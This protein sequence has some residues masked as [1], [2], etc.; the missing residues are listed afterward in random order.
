MIHA[1]WTKNRA[2]G[3]SDAVACNL[4]TIAASIRERGAARV[5]A[6]V[7]VSENPRAE[8]VVVADLREYLRRAISEARSSKAE[9]TGREALA[10]LGGRLES[11]E[12][13]L[14]ALDNAEAG[15]L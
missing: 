11:F 14:E 1:E 12:W 8:K 4:E 15:K 6:E 2:E 7:V 10:A 9:S 13:C 5:V 3:N